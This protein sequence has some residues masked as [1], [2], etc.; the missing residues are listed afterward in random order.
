MKIEARRNNYPVSKNN[1]LEEYPD[2]KKAIKSQEI[3]VPDILE[4]RIR[5]TV[6]ESVIKKKRF[7][8]RYVASI[9]ASI[10]VVFVLLIQ[11]N[12]SFAESLSKIPVV[13]EIVRV[14]Y[15]DKGYEEAT[16]NGFEALGGT[17]WEEDGYRLELYDIYLD[18]ERVTYK[19]K[20]SG[21]KVNYDV[22]N[23]ELNVDSKYARNTNRS[24]ERNGNA[25]W[26]KGD[27][28]VSVGSLRKLLKEENPVITFNFSI[29]PRYSKDPTNKTYKV[30]VPLNKED[31]QLSKRY[32]LTHVPYLKPIKMNDLTIQFRKLSIGPTTM[33]LSFE[34]SHSPYLRVGFT[35]PYL[36]DDKGNRYELPEETN[37]VGSST[38]SLLLVPSLYYREMPEKLF[39]GYEGIVIMDK[40]NKFTLRLDDT[41]PKTIKY[42][43]VEY[44]VEKFAYIGGE[45]FFRMKGNK[46]DRKFFVWLK[47]AASGSGSIEDGIFFKIAEKDAYTFYFQSAYTPIYESNE[48]EIELGSDLNE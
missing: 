48:I 4:M 23:Y 45:L 10:L 38:I 34:Y 33:K 8:L 3:L 44:T 7:I 46:S 16:I 15:Q 5:K 31:F 21:N 27:S 22:Y 36:R 18:E 19:G 32:D 41:Y 26:L 40:D 43:G 24:S 47:G 28:P 9:A 20:L 14:F 42:T 37:F 25:V 2:I 11:Y 6:E 13:K 17:V 35:N 39:F 29:S 30:T 12:K 1:D